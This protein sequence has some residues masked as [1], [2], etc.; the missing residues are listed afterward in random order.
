MT[1]TTTQL[2]AL[3]VAGTAL[4]N[5][6]LFF[7]GATHQISCTVAYLMGASVYAAVGAF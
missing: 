7:S 2:T 5:V 6:A 3:V 1:L 4:I